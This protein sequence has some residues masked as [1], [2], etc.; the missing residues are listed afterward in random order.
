MVN[1]K[2]DMYILKACEL[3]KRLGIK[4][5]LNQCLP[6]GLSKDYYPRYKLLEQYLKVI[7]NGYSVEEMAQKTGVITYPSEEDLMKMVTGQIM[8]SQLKLFSVLKS[9][10]IREDFRRSSTAFTL[11]ALTFR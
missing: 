7:D 10:K 6:L 4:L 9:T 5:K 11:W 1:E 8:T 3:A 2:N